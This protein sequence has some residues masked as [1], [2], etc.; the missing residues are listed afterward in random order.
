MTRP[1]GRENEHLVLL[2][3]GLQV[4]H[5]GC[6]I[7]DVG[8]PVD[9]A[10][11]PV[12]VAGGAVVLVRP[13]RGDAPLGALVHLDGPDLHLDDLAARP[14]DRG[15]QALVEVELRHRDVV[16]EPAHHRLVTAVDATERGVA[17][18]HRVDDHADRDEVEDVVELL[19]LLHHLLVDAPQVLAPTGDLGL[20]VELVQTAADLG[21]RLGQVDLALG[22]AR[23]DEMVE[24][25]EALRVQRGERRGP[26][27]AASAP[28][29]RGGAPA[30][31]RCR[32]SPGRCAA[33]SRW[34]SPRS[35][36]CCAG[37]RRA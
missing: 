31:R 8:L 34:A 27:V 5:E 15:V 36:A 24:L 6:R 16:L 11:Q 20:D 17:I 30:V 9:D 3:V 26:R 13:V 33:A 7:G 29:C 4:L 22:R 37:G 21:D 23:A 14:D 25:G 18:L 35:C 1:F 2:E 32:A 12:D 28:A 10:V 19:A